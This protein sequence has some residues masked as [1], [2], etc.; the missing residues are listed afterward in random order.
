MSQWGDQCLFNCA[1][2]VCPGPT[3]RHDVSASVMLSSRSSI[4]CH[5]TAV[6]YRYEAD[7]L[8]ALRMK[9]LAPPLCVRRGRQEGVRGIAGD[10]LGFPGLDNDGAHVAMGLS[11]SARS[12]AFLT[13]LNLHGQG[14][15]KIE[16]LAAFPALE[17]LVSSVVV[18]L[19]K[20]P[21]IVIAASLYL[22]SQRPVKLS[23]LS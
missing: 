4:A 12:S 1:Y 9:P 19:S 15:R 21:H 23:A 20:H 2:I 13:R 3:D 17:V 7:I 8:K 18:H 5:I 14:L 10:A 16:G 6:R 22:E 11:I